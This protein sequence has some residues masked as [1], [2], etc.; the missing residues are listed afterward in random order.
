MLCVVGAGCRLSAGFVWKPNADWKIDITVPRPM[1]AKRISHSYPKF[2]GGYLGCYLPKVVETA[3]WIYIAGELG[4]GSWAIRRASGA[5]DVVTYRDLRLIF[6]YERENYGALD[7]HA[8]I[9]CVFCRKYDY[10][11]ATPAIHP[12]AAIMLRLGA[13]Y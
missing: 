7:Y 3:N 1:I 2:D 10:D 6:G 11:S 13:T 12:G 4:G 8:E 5:N 9:A